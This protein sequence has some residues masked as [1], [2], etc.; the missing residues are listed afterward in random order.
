MFYWPS[1]RAT[2]PQCRRASCYI[3]LSVKAKSTLLMA[4]FWSGNLHTLHVFCLRVP[5]AMAVIC[6]SSTCTSGPSHAAKTD[7]QC[8][9]GTGQKSNGCLCKLKLERF[10][11]YRPAGPYREQRRLGLFF[12]VPRTGAA[13]APSVYI[14]GLCHRPRSSQRPKPSLHAVLGSPPPPR[15]TLIDYAEGVVSS[16]FLFPAQP[17]GRVRNISISYSL[18]RHPGQQKS[19]AAPRERGETKKP[20]LGF[21]GW[22]S[23]PHVLA[24]WFLCTPNSSLLSRP[25]AIHVPL[26]DYVCR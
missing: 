13:T 6:F 14:Y 2:L 11:T 22:I 12:C 26:L 8:K 25:S 4:K 18:A 15:L 17:P 21:A 23:V 9:S 1:S 20:H 10:Q 19:P 3:A 16:P 24:E 5:Y 7:I